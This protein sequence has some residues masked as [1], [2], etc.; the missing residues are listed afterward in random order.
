ME[1]WCFGTK[2]FRFCLIYLSSLIFLNLYQLDRRKYRAIGR[3]LLTPALSYDSKGQKL[4]NRYFFANSNESL[5]VVKML[6]TTIFLFKAEQTIYL[7]YIDHLHLCSDNKMYVNQIC[8][9]QKDP[10]IKKNAKFVSRTAR[11]IVS[12]WKIKIKIF[13]MMHCSTF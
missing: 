9:S 8:L 11:Q 2:Q 5:I 3:E 1:N 6:R 7:F 13:K 10:K 4:L 12:M